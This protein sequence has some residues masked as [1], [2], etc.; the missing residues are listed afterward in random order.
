MILALAE[1]SP[2]KNETIL[3]NNYLILVGLMCMYSIFRLAISYSHIAKRDGPCLGRSL[4][5]L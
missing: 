2:M 1:A 4:I 5:S 3:V